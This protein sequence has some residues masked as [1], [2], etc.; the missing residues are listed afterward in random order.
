MNSINKNS[1]SVV[2]DNKNKNIFQ[3]IVYIV[4]MFFATLFSSGLH[5]AALD[6]TIDQTQTGGIVGPLN[7]IGDDYC[8][9]AATPGCDFDNTDSI[10]R[11]NDD[12][13]FQF[14]ISVGSAGD[15]PVIMTVELDP[16]LLWPTLPS[17]CNVFTSSITGDGTASNPSILTC[18]LGFQA[19][20][21]TT[22]NV[23][24]RAMGDNLSG[25]TAGIASASID[26]P[27]STKVDVVTLPSDVTITASPRMNLKKAYY[28]NSVS[29]ID[30][31]VFIK[32]RYRWWIETW[33]HDINGNTSDDPDPVLG[34]EMI[35]GPVTFTEDPSSVSP[36]AYIDDCYTTTTTVFPYLTYNAT[37][38]ERSVINAGSS[39]CANTG[40]TATGPT[41]VTV[42]GADYS[43]THTPTQ[44]RGGTAISADKKIA[45]FGWIDIMIP[46]TDFIAAEGTISSVNTLSNF[47]PDSISGASNLDE[48]LSD[49][50]VSRNLVEGQGSWSKLYRHSMV[51]EQ[52]TGSLW[53]SPPTTASGNW[54]GDGVVQPGQYFATSSAYNNNSFAPLSELEI[55]D[56]IDTNL[57]DF[58]ERNNAPG[59]P[60]YV[61]GT[62]MADG[63]EGTDY[64][65]EYGTGY[66]G[67]WPPTTYP[68]PA[69]LKT[70]C[71]DASVQWFSSYTAA[72]A[73]GTVTKV[74]YRRLTPYPIGTGSIV[75]KHQVKSGL[76]DPN[77]TLLTNMA[78]FRTSNTS[79]EWHDCNYVAGEWPATPQ[80]SNTCGDRL[81][82]TQTVARIEK[83]TLPGDLIDQVQAGGTVTYQLSPTFTSVNA[84][85]DTVI[86]EDT[87]PAGVTYV[88]NSSLFG[89]VPTA[90]TVTGTSATGQVLTWNLGTRAA[91]AVIPSIE[92]SIQVPITANNGDILDNVATVIADT[93]SSSE[94]QRSDERRVTVSSP[95]TLIVAKTTDT[96]LVEQDTLIRYTVEYFNGTPDDISGSDIIDILPYDGDSGNP[97]SSFSGS[98]VVSPLTFQTSSGIAYYTNLSPSSIAADPQ[99]SSNTLPGGS[100]TWCTSSQFGIIGCPTGFAQVTAVRL[101]DSAV[102]PSKT[103]RSIT[104]EITPTGNLGGE[105]Y[106]NSAKA[107]GEGVSLTASSPFAIAQVIE[108]P[109]IGL[110]KALSVQNGS[111]LTFSFVIENLGNTNFSNVNL[112][113]DFDDAFGAG[114]YTVATLPAVTVQPAGGNLTASTTFTGN[115]GNTNLLDPTA[116]ND[117]PFGTTATVTVTINL[118]TLTDQGSGLGLYENSATTEGTTPSGIDYNDTSDN[119][120]D[121]DT[122]GDGDASDESDPTPI[123]FSIEPSWTLVKATTSEPVKKDDVMT[124]TFTVENTGNVAVSAITLTD[125]KCDAVPVL[126][127]G[128][129]NTNSILEETETWVYSCDYTVTQQEVDDGAVDNTASITGTPNGGT[130]ED[131]ESVVK[132]PVVPN[133]VLNIVK[134]SPAH[135][136][137]D[138]DGNVTLGDT[139]TYTITATNNGNISLNNVVVSDAKITPT[140]VTCAIVL[141]SATCD[142]T[143]THLVVAADTVEGEVEN[144]AEVKSDE[145]ITPIQS[146]TVETPITRII[147][148]NPEDFPEVNGKDGGVTT[149]VLAS[150]TLN[151]VAVVAADVTITVDATDPNLV[152]DPA[153]GLITVAPGTPAG[154]YD[155]TYT[156]CENLNPTNCSTTTETVV[157][158]AAEILAVPEVYPA[159]NGKDGGI[160]T[161]VLASDTLNGEPVVAADVTIAVDT[162]APELTLDPATG[163]ITVSP[164]TPAGSYDVT[165]TICE[166]LNPTNCSTTTETV[167]VEPPEILAIPESFPAVNGLEGGVTTSVLA[168]DTLNGDPVVA[169]DVTITVDATDPNLTLDPVTGLITVA[170]GTPAGQHTVTYTICENFNPTNCSTTTETVAVDVAPIS[171]IPEIF[172]VVNGL[173]GGVTTSVL[174]SDTLNLDPVDAADVTISVGTSAPELTLDPS[175][176]LIT[177]APNTPAGDYEVTYTICENLNP[178]NCATTIETV[179]VEAAEI[180]ALPETFPVVNGFEG[181]VTTSVLASDTLNGDPVVATDVTLTVDASDPNLILDPVTGLITVAAGTPAGSYDVTY[182]ICEN[183]NPTNCSTTTET[184]TVEPAEI[185]AIPEVYPVINGKDGGVTTTVLASDTLNGV[186][187]VPADV[188]ITVDV[189]DP[190]LTLDPVTGLIT[191]APGTPAGS[192]DVT[193]T[194]CENLNP[195][196]CSTTTETVTVEAAEILAI[197][198]VYPEINGKDGGVTTTVLASDTLNGVAVVPADVTITVDV[199]DPNLTLDPA[200][201]LITVAPGTPAGSYDV[202]YTICEKLNPT[203]CSTTTEKVTVVEADIF[204]TPEAF[205][206]ING[207]EGGVTTSVLASDTLN[208]DLVVP[209]DVTITVDASD[210]NLILDPVTGLITVASGTPAGDYTVTYT[211]CENLNPTNCSTT[212]ETVTVETAEI[213][214]IPEVYPVINGKDGG[215]TTTVLASD[216]LNGVA[217][218]PADVTITV[219]ASDPNLILDPATGLITVA[220]GTPAGDHTVTYT[221]C[222]NLN[223]TNCSTTTETVTVEAAEI[224]AIPEVYPVINGKDG[225]VTSTVLASDTLNGVAVVPADVTITVDASDPDLTLDP[226]TGLITVA[227]GTPAGDHT[228]TYTICESLNPTNCS[229]TTETVTVEAA[230]IQAIPEVYPVVNGNEGGLTTT[231]LAGDTLNGVAVEPS[232]VTITVDVSDSNLTLDP[233]TGLITVAPGTPAG[234]YTVTYTICENL[235]PTNCSTTT[236]TV[237]VVAPLIQAV[238]ETFEPVNGFE[239]GVTTSVLASD[240]LNGD[241]VVAADITI[242]VDSSAPELTLDPITGLITVAP[243]TPAGDYTVTYTICESLNPTSCSTTTETVTVEAAEIQAVTEAFEP[244]NG[245]EGGVTT[246]VLTSD[247]L[248]GEPVVAA[249]VTI[250][251]DTSAPELTLDPSTG[252]VT[253][254]PNTPAGDYTVTYTICESLNPTNCSTT[255]ET[256]TVEASEIQAV[257][258]TFEPI[259]GFEG[260]VTASVLTS[261]TLNGDPV[262][263]ADVT[264]SVDASAPELILD[265]NTGLITV[266]PNTPAGSYDVTYTICEKL[267][268]ENCS[269]T[270]ETVI[271]EAPLIGTEPDVLAAVDGTVGGAGN[272][273]VL[274]NDTI[275]EVAVDPE[276]VTLTVNSPTSPNITI[277]PDGTLIVAPGTPA[278]TYVVEYTVCEILNP[279]NCSSTT[280][281]VPVTVNLPPVAEDDRKDDQ[282]LGQPVTIQTVANDSDSGNNLDP[283]SVQLRDP[284]GNPVTTLVVSG[285]GIWTVDPVTGDITFTPETGYL[286]DPTPVEYTVKDKSGLESNIATVTIDYEEPA[287]IEGVVWLDSDKDNEIDPSEDRKAGWTIKVKDKNGNVIATTVTDAEGNYSITGLIPDEYTIELLNTNGTLIAT[288]STDGSLESGQKIDLSLPID[289][290]GLV[291]D[292]LSRDPISGVTL[293]LVNSSGIPV[294]AACVGE[295]QQNQTTTDDGFYAFDVYLDTHPSCPNGEIYTVRITSAPLGF[296]TDSTMIA[297][298]TGVYDSAANEVHCTLD[299]IPN[300]GSCEVQSQPEAPQG[301]ENTSYFFDFKLTSGDA[302]VIFNHLPIDAEIA[303]NPDL[304]DGTLLLTKAANKLQASVGDLV[305]YTITVVN[306]TEDEVTADI[307]DDLPSGFKFASTAA[308]LTRAGA[309]NDLGTTDDVVSTISATGNTSISFDSLKLIANEKVQIGYILKIGTTASQGNSVNT[310]Q[311]FNAGSSTDIASNIATATVAIVA[312]TVIDQATLVG[313]VYHDRDGDGYQDPANVTG[314]TVKSDYFGWNSLHLGGLNAR[315]SVLDDAS[316]YRKV[317]RMPW[318]RKNDF[319]VTTQQGTVITVDNSGQVSESHVGAKAKGW[320]SQDVRVTTRRTQGIPTQTPV[321]AM[322]KPAHQMDVL[323]I[324]ITNHGIHEEGIPGVRLATVK[325]LVIE[326]DGYGRYNIPDVDAGQRSMGQNFIIKVDM[327]TL[328]YGARMTTENP[329]VLRLTGTALE[330]INFGV[331]L[332]DKE[333]SESQ[334]VRV[335]LNSDFFKATGHHIKAT[336][337]EVM[338]DIANK[339]KQYGQGHI[340]VDVVTQSGMTA[341]DSLLRAKR[342]AHSV[343]TY[344]LKRLGSQIMAR[345]KVEVGTQ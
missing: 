118:H 192:Y 317:V 220:P 52:E 251:V 139:L 43:L 225:G 260:G 160:T 211:I 25:T 151:G 40:P 302:N 124:Y 168:S 78:T 266:A 299:A 141:P 94:A 214:A 114:N 237:T 218:V 100:T 68:N 205:P 329:R 165:Y 3:K 12:I 102:L 315:V 17:I 303:R 142:L 196:N 267:N 158:E 270:I 24:A 201:G 338:D 132:V 66:V 336:H 145:I 88:N 127:S 125:A 137:A 1:H 246:S 111:D 293:Q 292:S 38:P 195:T 93:D 185:Q 22:F 5:A 75:L 87:L 202:T 104:I 112:I 249:D 73:A 179:T 191:V 6:F 175:S 99:D 229:T 89:G 19:A 248:N 298:Q 120:T 257:T 233:A 115:G 265:P 47:D 197:P 33:K 284:S 242:T 255:T 103:G 76:T 85:S 173:E 252:L 340:I 280:A 101:I 319:K 15:D 296:H 80:V 304:D 213:Q 275:N 91:N 326:T 119:G 96:P 308:K 154:S 81:A 324:T 183:L 208:G 56:V 262:V 82:L 97:S 228:V 176:G 144:T 256:V 170:P 327:A 312:D 123:S 209:A 21:A 77:G 147:E 148:A 108:D 8:P 335:E 150:D 272:I 37:Y 215:V 271:V 54:A 289:P 333:R 105:K 250:T 279:T 44:T 337:H 69:A 188:T 277:N 291:Y 134:G 177:V 46:Q 193:Y 204:A 86:I 79:M 34:N 239:G 245:F 161:S 61:Y 258:E 217:V 236:E 306:T 10:V 129:L 320:T 243:G 109:E 198:E 200:T 7:V 181:G 4:L 274:I 219:D 126:N 253:V 339:I 63:V 309:D 313:K 283:T 16:G 65:V 259:N 135:T 39:A 60:H 23:S 146:N 332:L 234:D 328:P 48:D 334:T 261:D 286:G 288:M 83:T 32:V 282:R 157:V 164:S 133:P 62:G 18:N 287:A 95:A 71:S 230:E 294:D 314:L 178:T 64:V 152:L 131:L 342:R 203:N 171:A 187:V 269:T 216:T 323:E 316:K 51:L 42:T 341:Q 345:V 232:D 331:K 31:A 344:L 143:G 263:A 321:V 276:L 117:L 41:T 90:P 113:D 244:I 138:S 58:A 231:V 59:T 130:L 240:S 182:T 189:S 57:Y 74:K 121:S 235:N 153:T 106:T 268:P 72:K 301:S 254:A 247:T 156:I 325:G 278:G 300:S 264:I 55:C 136:D 155:V 110:A 172:P 84:I 20:L 226:A 166:N 26:A 50:T 241:P 210:P 35:V 343:K 305:Y 116:V 169:A 311:A 162:S 222:E 163:L 122:D 45:T 11:T 28:S 13:E 206:E 330:K 140:S 70:E 98:I 53:Y 9:T 67:T 167:T 207:L 49:N 310:A 2:K 14:N 128:D 227:A 27:N 159:I 107:A 180:Q 30:G 184:V 281:T 29:T 318:G 307:R 190:N 238:A 223:P 36:N 224:Q 322:R 199:S 290:S 174:A 221:I 273:N 149:T 295:G 186:A 297:P 194:I 92:F 212:T 285:E